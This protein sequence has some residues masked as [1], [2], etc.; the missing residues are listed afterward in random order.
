MELKEN[1]DTELSAQE[2]ASHRS[3][4]SCWI[5]VD[6]NV[7]DVTSYLDKHPGGAA[8]LLKQGGTVRGSLIMLI[9]YSHHRVVFICPSTSSR[10]LECAPGPSLV[11]TEPAISRRRPRPLI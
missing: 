3:T 11:Q 6:G 9:F 5:V 2:I 10:L 8:V 1:A 4:S 7:Y